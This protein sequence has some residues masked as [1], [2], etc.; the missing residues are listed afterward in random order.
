MPAA[1]CWEPGS[2]I[3]RGCRILPTSWTPAPTITLLQSMT[4]KTA[5]PSS[6]CC[7]SCAASPT[8]SWW[9]TSQAGA[10]R[11]SSSAMQSVRSLSRSGRSR[12]TSSR[13]KR[14]RQRCITL[15]QPLGFAG[16]PA[17]GVGQSRGLR[18][19]A[20]RS[21]V[22][23]V[24]PE[25][26]ASSLGKPR[27]QAPLFALS[28]APAGPTPAASGT[29]LRSQA[30]SGTSVTGFALGGTSPPSKRQRRG[31]RGIYGLP[32]IGQ[33]RLRVGPRMMRCPLLLS[34]VSSLIV[35]R[36]VLR[37]RESVCSDTTGQHSRSVATDA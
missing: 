33:A 13:F 36:L 20:K 29:C 34:Q 6:P 5:V 8:S 18:P 24:F 12:Y 31:V 9:R 30:P 3:S 16:P 28:S 4:P 2:D 37:D 7:N 21:V 25:T 17:A 11:R 10:F 27:R 35:G 22:A 15:G 14:R 1:S 19:A 23:R 32:A 26:L